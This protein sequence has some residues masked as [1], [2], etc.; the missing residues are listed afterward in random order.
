MLARVSWANDKQKL[1]VLTFLQIF[2]QNNGTKHP[3][4]LYKVAEKTFFKIQT[5]VLGFLKFVLDFS[6]FHVKP[7]SVKK[8][9]NDGF[10]D[11]YMFKLLE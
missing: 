7:V 10:W 8:N 11:F 3:T 9:P 5:I 6:G 1:Y 4:Y 2:L